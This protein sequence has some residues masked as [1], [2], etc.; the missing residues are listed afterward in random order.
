MRKRLKALW[1]DPV[2]SAVIAG[3]ILAA[4]AALLSH[5]SQASRFWWWLVGAALLVGIGLLFLRARRTAKPP[6]DVRMKVSSVSTTPHVALIEVEVY[7]TTKRPVRVNSIEFKTKQYW[8]IH[9]PY[10]DGVMASV[11]DTIPRDASVITISRTEDTI[12]SKAFGAVVQA[13]GSMTST[14]R[15]VTDHS[16]GTCFGIFPFH[17]GVE[18]KYGPNSDSLRLSDIVVSLH[19]SRALSERTM[20]SALPGPGGPETIQQLANSA[21]SVVNGSGALCPP[22]LL[23]KLKQAVRVDGYGPS[24]RLWTVRGEDDRIYEGILKPLAG[25]FHVDITVD[26][27]LHHG[28]VFSSEPEA[29]TWAQSER[30]RFERPPNMQSS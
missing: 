17:L 6:L 11:L 25:A 16:P 7:N 15:L 24:R 18:M 22:E 10:R 27:E 21:L 9:D 20:P 2:L 8:D 23:L 29:L 4:G 19:S 13:R 3:V 30:H 1:R 12:A 26:D 28:M 14:F 5:I